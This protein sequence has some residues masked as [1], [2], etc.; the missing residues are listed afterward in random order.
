GLVGGSFYLRSKRSLRRM[1]LSVLVS[2]L[3]YMWGV[4]GL[5]M[6]KVDLTPAHK[7][8]QW[9]DVRVSVSVP[10]FGV[11]ENNVI[12]DPVTLPTETPTREAAESSERTTPTPQQ[13]EARRETQETPATS[14]TTQPPTPEQIERNATSVPRRSET[15]SGT[16]VSRSDRSDR[17]GESSP[18]AA[19]EPQRA[20]SSARNVGAPASTV[21]RTEASPAAAQRE[22]STAPAASAS[23]S[24]QAVAPL[25][26]RTTETPMSSQSPSAPRQTREATDAPSAGAQQAQLAAASQTTPE[27]R[28]SAAASAIRTAATAPDAAKTADESRAT[29]VATAQESGASARRPASEIGQPQEVQGGRVEVARAVSPSSARAPEAF[30]QSQSPSTTAGSAATVQAAQANVQRGDPGPPASAAARLQSTAASATRSGS[31]ALPSA[32]APSQAARTATSSGG[33]AAPAAQLSRAAGG[34]ASSSGEQAAQLEIAAAGGSALGSPAA[35]GAAIHRASGGS[36]PG[37]FARSGVS[38]D[39]SPAAT[40]GDLPAASLQ[41]AAEGGAS[42]QPAAGG[43]SIQIAR[44]TAGQS[45]GPLGEAADAVQLSNVPGTGAA[46]G[47]PSANSGSAMIARTAGTGGA[48][49]VRQGSSGSGET[50][51]NQ[52]TAP[53][54]PSI[55]RN[56]GGSGGNIAQGAAATAGTPG[57]RRARGGSAGEGD[58]AAALAGGPV[59]EPGQ[60]TGAVAGS[61]SNTVSRGESGGAVGRGS[62][63]GGAAA[64]SAATGTGDIGSANVAADR[65]QAGE[66]A[67]ALAAAGTAA[68]RASPGES[69]V[70]GAAA[71]GIT[72]D[73][74]AANG[75]SAGSIA[76]PTGATFSR[77]DSAA[78]F[79]RGS[80][81]SAAA[82]GSSGTSDFARGGIA[83]RRGEGNGEGNTVGSPTPGQGPTAARSS[84]SGDDDAGPVAKVT[85]AAAGSGI[86]A[87]GPTG[88]APAAP[89]GGLGR[90]TSEGPSVVR[91][92]GNAVEGNASSADVGGTAIA[93]ATRSGGAD[94]AG[95]ASNLASGPSLSRTSG[96][97]AEGAVLAEEI[98]PESGAV[99]G[100]P[101]AGGAGPASR[102]VTRGEENALPVQIAARPGKGGLSTTPADDLGTPSRLARAYADVVHTSLQR[103]VLDRSQSIL[104]LESTSPAAA[105]FE[106]RDP[107]RRG[108][109]AKSRGGSSMSEEAVEAG[110]DFLARHQ[111][112]DGR[113]SLQEWASGRGYGAGVG[114]GTMQ[115]DSAATG[116]AL[117]AF[118]G[119]GYT[120]QQDKYQDVVAGGLEY[121]VKN[122]KADGDLFN[123]GS[124]Y[125]WLYSHGIASIALCEA[126][127]MTRDEK[128]REPAQKAIDFIVAAQHKELGGWRYAPGVGTDTS[129]TGWQMMA[130][131]SGELG[132][133]NVPRETYAAVGRWVESAAAPRDP[134]FYVY[135]PQSQQEHQRTPSLAMTAEALLIRL[136]L[137]WSPSDARLVRGAQWLRKNLPAYGPDAA[138]RDA[139]YWYYATQVMIHVQGEAWDDWNKQ[140]RSVLVETQE[141][142]GP[143]GGSWDPAGRYPDRWGSAGG[144]IYTTAMH[145][146]MLE[147]YYRHLPLYGTQAA[148]PEAAAAR[149]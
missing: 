83:A 76:S 14:P 52:G 102:Q 16:E 94:D 115:A 49:Q 131:K 107:G 147:V 69:D 92:S 53:G 104:T 15:R 105:A 27:L 8:S 124:K 135:R 99:A 100:N 54:T 142:T 78:A 23:P 72:G 87:G 44:S 59:A 42:G 120:H 77:G 6:I 145:L 127:G 133:L 86:A 39:G 113:W 2:L 45:A 122:Q 109:V 11:A 82:A 61:P 12:D 57:G 96:G 25:E 32:G 117:L 46:L 3:I 37:N 132:G 129:V 138:K 114:I 144:R 73:S 66:F 91:G 141:K 19:L 50:G 136:Y 75:N 67:P 10:D 1:H 108:D 30:A 143:L 47:G 110:L 22:S 48:P 85:G 112:P 4:V 125:C 80:G 43:Q 55:A 146:L 79:S 140:L 33:G 95:P 58:P 71:A 93:R 68:R 119:A 7:P 98:G 13:P 51:G 84:R 70:P 118:L 149:P 17:S 134:S 128:L 31:T 34:G 137:G 116:L 123:G 88:G 65:G 139:Y 56:A 126:Y 20:A 5:H 64:A 26:R 21:R 121:L 35:R 101:S 24:R 90:G 62:S 36:S 103:F 81:G 106:R 60:G 28:P 89:A 38:G 74:V 130:L 41:R 18:A 29:S 111:M 9:N 63:G 40:Q 97:G 148:A